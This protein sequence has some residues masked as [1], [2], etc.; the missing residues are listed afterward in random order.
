MTLYSNTSSCVYIVAVGGVPTRVRHA[1]IVVSILYTAVLHVG[2]PLILLIFSFL[3]SLYLQQLHF[4]LM[5]D[6]IFRARSLI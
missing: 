4:D 2:D 3:L 6:I 5:L 1:Y